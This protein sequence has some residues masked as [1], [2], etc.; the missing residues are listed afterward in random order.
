MDT[1]D[2]PGF[3]NP[4]EIKPG[5]SGKK[6][7]EIIEAVLKAIDYR[8]YGNPIAIGSVKK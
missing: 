3:M 2:N 7:Y 5:K 8:E 1:F 6:I 4:L